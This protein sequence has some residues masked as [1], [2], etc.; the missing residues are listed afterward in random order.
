MTNVCLLKHDDHFLGRFVQFIFI[1]ESI[2]GYIFS[3]GNIFYIEVKMVCYLWSEFYFFFTRKGMNEWYVIR[4]AYLK[5]ISHHSGTN[6]KTTKYKIFKLQFL[7]LFI[8]F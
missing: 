8:Y 5:M 6:I 4:E 7:F 1:S 3:K 2:E